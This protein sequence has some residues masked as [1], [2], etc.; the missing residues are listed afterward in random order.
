MAFFTLFRRREEERPRWTEGWEQKS[1]GD[2]GAA[3]FP[4]RRIHGKFEGR[5]RLRIGCL[6]GSVAT[7][8]LLL[9]VVIY[10]M[11]YPWYRYITY[12]FLHLYLYIL[13]FIVYLDQFLTEN[14]YHM[15]MNTDDYYQSDH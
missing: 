13:A 9:F 1:T 11:Y 5:A 2:E 4:T 6:H 7:I 14:L 3:G 10:Y 15:L 12:V 8:Y